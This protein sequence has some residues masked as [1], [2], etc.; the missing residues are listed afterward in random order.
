[1]RF[2]DYLAFAALIL[3]ALGVIFGVFGER[4]PYFQDR[5]PKTVPGPAVPVQ[6]DDPAPLEYGDKKANS[7]SPDRYRIA[8]S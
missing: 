4:G 7:V 2:I 3:T 5:S 6:F 1:M 8:I